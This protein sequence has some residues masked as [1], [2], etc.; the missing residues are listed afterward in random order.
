VEKQYLMLRVIMEYYESVNVAMG[1]GVSLRQ[2]QALPLRAG[3]GRMKDIQDIEAIRKMAG[4]IGQQLAA[5]EVE[6]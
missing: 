6:K 5:L 3:I 2:V 1:R 4:D